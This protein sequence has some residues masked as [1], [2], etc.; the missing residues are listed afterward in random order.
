[1]RISHEVC[2]LSINFDTSDTQGSVRDLITYYM[3][4]L[5]ILL[6]YFPDTKIYKKIKIKIILC[7]YKPLG[8]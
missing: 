6:Q 4:F 2:F 5:I 8:F 1:M 7:M 3:E